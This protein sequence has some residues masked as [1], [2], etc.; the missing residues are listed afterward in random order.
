MSRRL[1]PTDSLR[2]LTAAVLVAVYAFLATFGAALT[3]CREDDGHVALEWRGAACCD[4]RPT[5]TAGPENS[6]PAARADAAPDCGLCE[7][8]PASAFLTSLAACSMRSS[9]VRAPMELPAAVVVAPIDVQWAAHALQPPVR[10]RVEPT[11][12]PPLAMIRTVVLRC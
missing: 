11:P 2:R 5:P 4:D 10:S 3:I 9:A 7:D 12:P 8:V 6:V 1:V